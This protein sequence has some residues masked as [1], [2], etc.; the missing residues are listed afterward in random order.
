MEST[1]KDF[2]KECYYLIRVSAVSAL[3]SADLMVYTEGAPVQVRTNRM[4]KEQIKAGDKEKI[5]RYYSMKDFYINLDIL[6]GEL[7][8]RVVRKVDNK[9]LYN[10]SGSGS[11]LFSIKVPS[12]L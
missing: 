7:T 9:E 11:K 2:C 8:I 3:V 12:S 5:Y 10:L 4:I 6:V 1:A